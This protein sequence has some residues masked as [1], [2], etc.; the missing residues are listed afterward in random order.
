MRSEGSR[1]PCARVQQLRCLD[2]SALFRI[3]APAEAHRESQR[4]TVFCDSVVLIVPLTKSEITLALIVLCGRCLGL[5][6][7]SVITFIMANDTLP[8]GSAQTLRTTAKTNCSN[9]VVPMTQHV[10]LSCSA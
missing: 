2:T 8:E 4:S 10:T 7:V 3:E 5:Q 9:L 6:E 1:I